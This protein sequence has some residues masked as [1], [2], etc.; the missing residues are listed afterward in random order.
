MGR[1][2]EFNYD[3][4]LDIA[5]E[6]FWTQGYNVTSITDLE[7]HMGMNRSSIYPNYGDKKSLLIKCLTK[8]LKSRV[9]EYEGILNDVQS[10]ATKN[11]KKIFRLAVDH[12]IKEDRTC[13]A[14]KLS[15]EIA[16]TDDDI[17]RLLTTNEKKIEDI[18]FEILKS[19]QQQGCFK[20]DLNTRVTAD[21][22]ACSSAALFKNYALNRNR[23]AIYDMIETLIHMVKA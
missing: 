4:K 21:F 18:Y 3:Q 22:F 19:G 6:L 16:I 11:L 5:L 23:K 9:S 20:S 7:H 17:R 13:L 8:Y 12:S 10:D 15:F 2:K 1:H 14:V